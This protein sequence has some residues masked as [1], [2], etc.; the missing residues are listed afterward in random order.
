MEPQSN[1]GFPWVPVTRRRRFPR[2]HADLPLRIRDPL[3]R[4]LDGH[5]VVLS[6]GGLGGTVAETLAVG[7][8]VQLQFQV[9]THPALFEVWA[10]VRDHGGL[11]HGFEFVFL[12]D[13]ERA[14]IRRFCAGLTI[15]SE[16]GRADL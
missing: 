2:Y 9:P 12:S 4:N 8:V 11:H 16:P 10:I 15:Q 6:E 5:C 3:E 7:G 14:A 1:K 13:L